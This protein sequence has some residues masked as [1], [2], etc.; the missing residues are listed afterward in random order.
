MIVPMATTAARQSMAIQLP[1]TSA[2]QFLLTVPGNVEVKGG[3]A[4]AD[5]TYLADINET[6][7]DLLTTREPFRLEMSLNNRLLKDEQVIVARSVLV[8]KLTPDEH[9]LHVTSSLEVIHGAVEQVG[10]QIP[11]GYQVS[12]VAAD[13]LSQ[14]EIESKRSRRFPE[15]TTPGGDT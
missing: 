7:F 4:V 3:L 2:S 5:R 8:H 6:Q 9:Q 15:S 1:T 14:W 11:D 13:L 12:H 10:F